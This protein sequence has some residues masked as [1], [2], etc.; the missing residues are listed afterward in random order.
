MRITRN[1]PCAWKILHILLCGT[2][3][4]VF[5]H[6]VISANARE[7]QAF[8]KKKTWGSKKSEPWRSEVRAG[9]MAWEQASKLGTF[10]D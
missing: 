4:R 3:E 7:N 10:D 5:L 2:G 8:M 9:A 1:D 6:M